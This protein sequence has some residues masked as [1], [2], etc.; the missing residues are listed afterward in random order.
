MLYYNMFILFL[1]LISL[2]ISWGCPFENKTI[3]GV[4]LVTVTSVAAEEIKPITN[5]YGKSRMKSTDFNS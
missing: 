3:K 1:R 2:V 5:L 4:R